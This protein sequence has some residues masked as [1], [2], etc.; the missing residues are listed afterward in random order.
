MGVGMSG[1]GSLIP[2]V[3][4]CLVCRFVGLPWSVSL[5]GQSVSL[6]ACQCEHT[7]TQ[8]IL[9]CYTKG[10]S[11][12]VHVN[13]LGR[14][15]SL[16]KTTRALLLWLRKKSFSPSPPFPFPATD[17]FSSLSTLCLQSSVLGTGS[18]SLHIAFRSRYSYD[19]VI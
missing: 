1:S 17:P 5:L 19:T 8:L 6:L 11:T 2:L 10:Y 13:R 15:S 16:K 4:M 18:L 14:A 12:T 3:R 9:H 7:H